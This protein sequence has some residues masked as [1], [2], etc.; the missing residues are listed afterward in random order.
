M[1]REEEIARLKA[2]LAAAE[3]GYTAQTKAK[4]KRT[5]KRLNSAGEEN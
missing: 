1:N 4:D 5:V 2:A 3:A